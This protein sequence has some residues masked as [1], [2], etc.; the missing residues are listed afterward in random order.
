MP[1]CNHCGAIEGEYCGLR[2]GSV[3][4][5]NC[6]GPPDVSI[7]CAS[8]DAL[9]HHTKVRTAWRFNGLH[10]WVGACCLTRIRE[11]GDKGYA[12][13][14]GGV[15]LYSSEVTSKRGDDSVGET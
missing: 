13:P 2:T 14:N 15:R 7:R 3:L 5:E 8:C 4:K 10:A 6:A 12:S 1:I 11:A 9:L